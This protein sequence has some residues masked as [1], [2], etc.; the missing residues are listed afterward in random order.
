MV[1]KCHQ[2]AKERKEGMCVPPAVAQ[3]QGSKAA[4]IGA[5][6]ALAALVAAARLRAASGKG[7]KPS[8]LG[9]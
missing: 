8:S 1:K 7:A 6:A 9:S 3:Q 4:A 5:Q 2:P